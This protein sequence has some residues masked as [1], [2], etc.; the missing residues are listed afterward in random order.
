MK[1]MPRPF[2]LFFPK[3][4]E[5]CDNIQWYVAQ[6]FGTPKDMTEDCE[7]VDDFMLKMEFNMLMTN[8]HHHNTKLQ[9]YSEAER[10]LID[11]L[12]NVEELKNWALGSFDALTAE[13]MFLDRYSAV[14]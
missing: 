11:K 13:L 9:H 1:D 2:K 8:C 5:I 3:Y 7:L 14:S 4:V 10:G 12:Q 6:K